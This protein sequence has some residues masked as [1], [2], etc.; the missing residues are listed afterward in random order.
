MLQVSK[1]ARVKNMMKKNY[2][3]MQRMIKNR[4]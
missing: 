2:N 4:C 3:Q 1:P